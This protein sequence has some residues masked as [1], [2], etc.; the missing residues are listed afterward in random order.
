MKRS[1]YS[2]FT[3]HYSLPQRGIGLIEVVVG[4]AILVLVFVGFFGVLQLGT[5]LATDS[6]AR[7][8]ALSL[9]LERMELMRSLAYKDIGTLDEGD[10]NNGHGN[11]PDGYDEGNPGQGNNNG[12]GDDYKLF[13]THFEY[14]TLNGIDYTRRTLIVYIDEE[15]RITQKTTTKL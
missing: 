3:I 11:D 12:L 15:A 9:A 1:F 7:T 2:L 14:I 4:T 13:S 5:R 6:K 10:A 8:G